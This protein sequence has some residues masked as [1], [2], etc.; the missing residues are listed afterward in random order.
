MTCTT[1]I[2]RAIKKHPLILLWSILIGGLLLRLV[3]LSMR[4]INPDEGAHLMDARLFLEGWTPIAEFGSRQP[5]YVYLLSISLKLFGNELWAGRLVPIVASIASCALFY[6]L[7]RR[8]VNRT[9]GLIAAAIYAFLPLSF[10]WGTVVKTEQIAIFFV[11]SSILFFSRTLHH[12]FWYPGWMILSGIFAALAFYVRQPTLYLPLAILAFT[13]FRRDVPRAVSLRS[14]LIFI[15]GYVGLCLAVCTPF[16]KQMNG[17]DI[18]F[19]QL[20][21]LQLVWNRV[22]HIFSQVP[23]GQRV[24]DTSGFRILDQDWALT[25]AAWHDALFFTLFLGVGAVFAWI[26]IR[27]IIR[28]RDRIPFAFLGLWFTFGLLLYGYQTLNRGFYTQY[29]LELLPSLLLLASSFLGYWGSQVGGRGLRWILTQ[30]GLYAV[31]FMVQKVFWQYYPGVEGLFLLGFVVGSV[32]V[33]VLAVQRHKKRFAGL[34][35]FISLLASAVFMVLNLLGV[36]TIGSLVIVLALVYIGMDEIWTRHRFAGSQSVLVVPMFVLVSCFY[37]SA[38]YS[39]YRIG[40]KYDCV[41]SLESKDRVVDL[42]AEAGT[43]NDEVLSGGMIWTFESGMIPFMNTPH[44]TEFL[45]VR[46]SEFEQTFAA[47]PPEFIVDDG[48][49]QRKFQRYWPFLERQIRESYESIATVQGSEY[50]IVVYRIIPRAPLA[51]APRQSLTTLE[52]RVDR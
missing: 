30:G 38:L 27:R 7:G 10:I 1:M 51:P 2:I 48:Y 8:F 50:P 16:L 46:A 43:L 4:W 3:L 6:I 35:I 36:G 21:P 33:T 15:L 44:P 41:W 12:K 45:K 28:F 52:S 29:F 39:G 31:F 49:T 18:L 5:V 24:V 47:D 23:A 26:Y 32:T 37:I 17:S 11:L 22:L 34:A 42:L 13:L 14:A 19:S 20:N 9:T 40:P 25:W